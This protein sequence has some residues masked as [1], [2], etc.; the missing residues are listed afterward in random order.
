MAR[1]KIGIVGCGAIGSSLA[2]Q[3]TRDFKRSAELAALYDIDTD[4]AGVLAKRLSLGKNIVVGNL[5]SLINHA[6][7][8]VE[9]ASA[10]AAFGIAA[11]ALSKGRSI[12]I[13]SAGGVVGRFAKLKRLAG[14]HNCRIYIPSG[15]ICGIDG[16]KAAKVSRIKKVV[17]T[18]RKNPAAFKGVKYITG[19]GIRLERIKKDRVLFAGAVAGSLVSHPD[20]IEAEIVSEAFLQGVG[21]EE[22]IVIQV[23]AVAYE[24]NGSFARGRLDDLARGVD[25]KSSGTGHRDCWQGDL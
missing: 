22:G 20:G 5:G 4:K 10:L 13:M 23:F 3:I 19:Q 6:Q 15:A 9:A 11:S 16:L 21:F 14:K 17:L 2:G 18:T 24:D 7:L 12:M 8:V 1:L 25:G